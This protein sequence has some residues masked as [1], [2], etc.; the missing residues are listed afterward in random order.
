M[1]ARARITGAKMAIAIDDRPT[2][3]ARLIIQLRAVQN[4]RLEWS[5]E[6]TYFNDPFVITLKLQMSRNE[7]IGANAMQYALSPVNS[8]VA[9]QNNLDYVYNIPQIAGTL[10]QSI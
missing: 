3:N 6:L 10:A 5:D 2:S 8:Q 7:R 1:A 9:V 4:Y